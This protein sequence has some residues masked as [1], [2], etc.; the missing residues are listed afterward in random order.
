MRI[1]FE[2]GARMGFLEWV[3]GRI[4]GQEMRSFLG[5]NVQL[6]LLVLAQNSYYKLIIFKPWTSYS[7]RSEM[8]VKGATS[9]T[10]NIHFLD[11]DESDQ[12]LVSGLSVAI[13][14]IPL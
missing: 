14:N 1:W 12:W 13:A 5:L 6:L 2:F 9:K 10:R 3:I 7:T 8:S 4:F 11:S